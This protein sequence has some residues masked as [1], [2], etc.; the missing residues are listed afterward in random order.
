MVST[1]ERRGLGTAARGALSGMRAQMCAAGRAAGCAGAGAP[2]CFSPD[3]SC[4]FSSKLPENEC[5]TNNARYSAELA[6]QR[7]WTASC[8]GVVASAALWPSEAVFDPVL[9]GA[10][11]RA[12]LYS[13]RCSLPLFSGAGDGRASCGSLLCLSMRSGHCVRPALLLAGRKVS[14]SHRWGR[15]SRRVGRTQSVIFRGSL[16]IV[17]RGLIRSQSRLGATSTA[18]GGV[19]RVFW[20]S[21]S[22]GAPHS[23]PLNSGW[24][25]GARATFLRPS[26]VLDVVV[27]SSE[28]TGQ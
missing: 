14:C 15:S 5:T 2:R 12:R 6:V 22:P 18:C 23:L 10:L 20:L 9:V 25:G 27:R 11:G 19:S 3:S 1:R 28:H 8:R 26:T 21:E 24:R 4:L 7:C 13:S 16:Q 17:S